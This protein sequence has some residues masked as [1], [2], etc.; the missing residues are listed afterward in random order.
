MVGTVFRFRVG[1]SSL[2]MNSGCRSRV[3]ISPEIVAMVVKEEV[4]VTRTDKSYV[5]IAL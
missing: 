4:V 1:C 3:D 2:P 5:S